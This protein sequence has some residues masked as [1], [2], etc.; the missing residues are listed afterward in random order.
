MIT[1]LRLARCSI[2]LPQRSLRL[3][4]DAA[5]RQNDRD[6]LKQARR[7]LLR[8][9]PYFIPTPCASPIMSVPFLRESR[10]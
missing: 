1:G 10:S 6:E 2:D 8:R 4:E 5:I 9:A 3:D 7:P